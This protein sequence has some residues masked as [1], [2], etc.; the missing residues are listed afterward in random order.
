LLNALCIKTGI[1]SSVEKIVY[2]NN[3]EVNSKF[4]EKPLVEG[5][6]R[7]V[8]F[9]SDIKYTFKGFFVA[10]ATSD[11]FPRKFKCYAKHLRPMKNTQYF[12]F[13]EKNGYNKNGILKFLN[14]KVKNNCNL[15]FAFKD[16]I[17]NASNFVKL[18]KI[19]DQQELYGD[20]FLK[21]AEVLQLLKENNLLYLQY[22]K[23]SSN[24][25]DLITSLNKT[26]NAI[27]NN[28]LLIANFLKE[29]DK[30][31]IITLEQFEKA[32]TN[33]LPV[34]YPTLKKDE[35]EIYVSKII[36]NNVSLANSKLSPIPGS[37][38]FNL[39]K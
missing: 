23:D 5:H 4:F 28:C 8:V 33:A 34:I 12:K 26:V 29:V 6:G 11:S 22:L 14:K 35:I 32:L 30:T 2:N 16:V 18:I 21:D 37:V 38:F 15:N 31:K 36:A 20:K 10:D 39:E 3:S 24:K 19:I 7:N 1:K 17:N 13:L 27:N 9:L 25:K